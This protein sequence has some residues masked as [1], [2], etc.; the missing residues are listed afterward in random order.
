MSQSNKALLLVTSIFLLASCGATTPEANA[1]APPSDTQAPTHTSTDT[2]TATQTATETLTP[3]ITLT[4][5]E[6]LSP[7]PSET[8]TPAP[9]IALAVRNGNCRVGPGEAYISVSVFDE[10]HEAVAL[11]R[12]YDGDWVWLQPPDFNQRCW[13]HAGNMEFSS[14]LRAGVA[15]IVTSV[16][17]NSEVDAPTGVTAVRNGNTITFSWNAIFQTFEVGYLLEVR[18]CLNGNLVDFS[19]ATGGT[20]IT[21]NDTADCGGGAFGELRGKNKLGYSSA[22]RLPWP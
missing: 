17:T 15:F 5:T 14:D 20:S 21:L 12:D 1:T 22:V 11:G 18:Q 19:Y 10:G 16:V 6:T 2:A 3:T 8:P 13:V 9:V 4:P 7:T